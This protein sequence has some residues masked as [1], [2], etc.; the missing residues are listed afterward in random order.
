MKLKTNE[1]ETNENVALNFETLRYDLSESSGNVTNGTYNLVSVI[2][3]VASVGLL[4]AAP[5]GSTSGSESL[6]ALLVIIQ[7]A[8]HVKKKFISQLVHCISCVLQKLIKCF[9][10]TAISTYF[11]VVLPSNLPVIPVRKSKDFNLYF[12]LHHYLVHLCNN[13]T[14]FLLFLNNSC[15]I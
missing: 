15:Y 13:F 2:L 4:T 9:N 8:D 14:N 1:N 10:G 11:S 3:N 7:F 12:P 6:V 5:A